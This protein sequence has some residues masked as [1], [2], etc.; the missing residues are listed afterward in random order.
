MNTH[1]WHGPR[2]AAL[3]PRQNP[4]QHLSKLQEERSFGRC[5]SVGVTGGLVRLRRLTAMM[6]L[7]GVPNRVEPADLLTYLGGDGRRVLT[8]DYAEAG[9]P[10]AHL[11]ASIDRTH[12]LSAVLSYPP[13][14]I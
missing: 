11:P 2:M 10:G 12:V 1:G 3:T 8:M 7:I 4:G 14:I 13:G 6:T 9:R 5:Q